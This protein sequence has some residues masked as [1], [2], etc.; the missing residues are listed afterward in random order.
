MNTANLIQ[1]V[2]G[3]LILMTLGILFAI[4]H[5][6]RFSFSSTWPLLVIVFGVLKLAERAA[7]PADTRPPAANPGGNPS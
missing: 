5:F 3:P 7:L 6:G 2:R 1:S 4:D